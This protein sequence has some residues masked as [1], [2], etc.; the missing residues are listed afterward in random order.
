[1]F[2]VFSE[3]SCSTIFSGTFL[4]QKYF[5]PLSAYQAK[6]LSNKKT[7]NLKFR[8]HAQT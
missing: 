3:A 2:K 6:K 7:M 8:N 1:M 5:M 4:E